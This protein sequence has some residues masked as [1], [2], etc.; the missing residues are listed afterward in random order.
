M[1]DP[2]YYPRRLAFCDTVDGTYVD[3]EKVENCSIPFLEDGRASV[4]TY[5]GTLVYATEGDGWTVNG[6]Y[7]PVSNA[8]GQAA[9]KTQWKDDT[10]D[11]FW[12]LDVGIGANRNVA[13][14]LRYSFE[15]TL[16]G[17]GENEAAAGE[18]IRGRF[19]ITGS[20]PATSAAIV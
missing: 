20:E 17:V 12:Q 7:R 2:Q 11:L 15:G 16:L 14:T 9:I 5:D 18:P 19:V 10:R 4:P 13:A 1:A 3:I 6:T 8:S